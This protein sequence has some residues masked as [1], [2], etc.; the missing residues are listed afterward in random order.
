MLIAVICAC[1]LMVVLVG[2]FAVYKLTFDTVETPLEPSFD[3]SSLFLRG[4]TGPGSARPAVS[5]PGL[6]L[7]EHLERLRKKDIAGAY[8]DLSTALQKTTPLNDFTLSAKKNE[9]LFR[10]ITAYSVTDAQV[11]GD[12]ATVGGTVTYQSGDTSRVTASFVKEGGSWKIETL[13]LV[14]Q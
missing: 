2:A 8:K 5:N 1:V 10:D 11:S 12:T 9:P 4:V 3:L 14:Y 7:Q 13:A 6:V